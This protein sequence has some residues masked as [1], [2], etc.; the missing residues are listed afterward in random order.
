MNPWSINFGCLSSIKESLKLMIKISLTASY[1]QL[2]KYSVSYHISSNKRSLRL[3]NFE[4]LSCGAYWMAVPKKGAPYFKVTVIIRR[5]FEIFVIFSFQATVNN[6]HFHILSY[7]FQNYLFS[8]FHRL[9]TFLTC[10]LIQLWSGYDQIYIKRHIL[11]CG[12]YQRQALISG[13]HLFWSKCPWSQNAPPGK[14]GGG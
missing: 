7:I 3:F 4:A 5:K 6:Y 8:F 13:C 9:Y 11:K 12:A 10:I 14:R 2:S 1:Y